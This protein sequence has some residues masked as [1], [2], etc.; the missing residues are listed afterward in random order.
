MGSRGR[1]TFLC[2]GSPRNSTI[3][4]VNSQFSLADQNVRFQN[5]SNY[6]PVI[7]AYEFFANAQSCISGIGR[8]NTTLS[9]YGAYRGCAFDVNK[10]VG[11][12]FTC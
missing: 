11:F 1:L 6:G 4:R 8:L 10:H 3:R 5:V 9:V 2:E 7:T 12:E